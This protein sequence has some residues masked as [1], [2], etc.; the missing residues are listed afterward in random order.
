MRARGPRRVSPARAARLRV[1]NTPLPMPVS[2]VLCTYNGERWLPE[3]WRSLL[4][5][6]HVPDEIVVRDDASS[7]GTFALLENLRGAA[8]AR[9]VRVTLARNERNLGFV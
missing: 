7:D 3:L 5:Q 9:G 6:T 8:L 1:V 4:A 2:V